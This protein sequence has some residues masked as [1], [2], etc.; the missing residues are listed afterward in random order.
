MINYKIFF[1]VFD[2][3]SE[4]SCKK[5]YVKLRVMGIMLQI[6]T[7]WLYLASVSQ[8]CSRKFC[9]LRFKINHSNL[10]QKCR[11]DLKKFWAWL[12]VAN[13]APYCESKSWFFSA[14]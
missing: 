8:T 9:K 13:A 14:I 10:V 12:C 5:N 6:F 1:E 4:K 3:K 11:V 2:C 7:A